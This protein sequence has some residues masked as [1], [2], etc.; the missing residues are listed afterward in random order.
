MPLESLG[1]RS[2]LSVNQLRI[3]NYF[4]RGLV[5]LHYGFDLRRGFGLLAQPGSAL[6]H[7]VDSVKMSERERADLEKER[8]RQQIVELERERE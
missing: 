6:C 3:L 1:V 8:E 5:L 7:L 4:E 2:Q